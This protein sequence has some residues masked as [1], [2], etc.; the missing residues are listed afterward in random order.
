MDLEA[1]EDEEMYVS[2]ASETE[3]DFVKE[4]ESYEGAVQS[5]KIDVHSDE[6]PE[7]IPSIERGVRYMD[8][9][10]GSYTERVL[11][12]TDVFLLKLKKRAIDYSEQ[13]TEQDIRDF[14]TELMKLANDSSYAWRK[15]VDYHLKLL[16]I[17]FHSPLHKS[18]GAEALKDLCQATVW[19]ALDDEK[20]QLIFSQ[21]VLG[22]RRRFHQYIVAGIKRYSWTLYK[23]LL[24]TSTGNTRDFFSYL[25]NHRAEADAVY[26]DNFIDKFKHQLAFDKIFGKHPV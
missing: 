8:E 17:F 23:I 15:G 7:I 2:G 13:L 4:E 10:Y 19:H 12:S 3:T 14:Y 9:A 20:P 22:M 16:L 26:R 1:D 6:V 11:Q 18:M 21:V 24:Y 25:E 5:D